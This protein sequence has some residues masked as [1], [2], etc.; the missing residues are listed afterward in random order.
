MLG[1]RG[2]ELLQR[3]EQAVVLGIGHRRRIEHVVRVVVTLELGSKPLDPGL[4]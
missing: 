1:M 2:L 3:E 4:G